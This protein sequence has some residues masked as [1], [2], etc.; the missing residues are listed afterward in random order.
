MPAHTL[1]FFFFFFKAWKKKHGWESAVNK[2]RSSY[3][4][5]VCVECV[6]SPAEHQDV[7]ESRV[8][9]QRCQLLKA[10]LFAAPIKAVRAVNANVMVIATSAILHRA[11]T[12]RTL[13]EKINT[14]KWLLN[15]LWSVIISPYLWYVAISA[16]MAASQPYAIINKL[17][18][19]VLHCV[20]TH[21]IVCCAFG[22]TCQI[23]PKIWNLV[24]DSSIVLI[25][26]I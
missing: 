15:I 16:C 8:L 14:L 7:V 9:L 1:L 5:Y 13:G 3:S 25:K 10:Q 26:A 6:I 2:S 12:R 19:H 21:A 23:V 24:F 20:V 22:F 18:M 17:L 4:L 11:Q